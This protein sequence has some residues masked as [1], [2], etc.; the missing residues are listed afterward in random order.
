MPKMNLIS[1]S[2]KKVSFTFTDDIVGKTMFDVINKREKNIRASHNSFSMFADTEKIE[3]QLRH[4]V[5]KIS[6][7]NIDMPKI[8]KKLDKDILNRIHE[9]FHVVEELYCAEDDSWDNQTKNIRTLLS[10]VNFLVHELEN[11]LFHKDNEAY[12][13][14]YIGENN[15]S[16]RAVIYPQLRKLFA[17]NPRPSKATLQ[18]GYATV[19]KNLL[20]AV[21]DNDVDM[22]K[23]GNLRPQMSMSTETIW[24]WSENIDN[25]KM[26]KQ[27]RTKW[28]KDVRDFVVKN[29]LQDY[30]GW[31]D[32]IHYNSVQPY[33]AYTDEDLSLTEW[34]NIIVKDKLKEI[35]LC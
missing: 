24:S 3:T 23:N 6:S 32:P 17:Y 19:G 34:H 18:V 22:I 7:Y 33:Y 21:K 27:K 2:G 5:E 15:I 26:C 16:D 1:N 8:P 14:F 13:V 31:K 10:D 12:S 30:V 11:A 35:E 29:K 4:K 25:G 28:D 20:H 9:G